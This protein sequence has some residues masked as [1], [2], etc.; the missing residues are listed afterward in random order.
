MNTNTN[1][2]KYK[3]SLTREQRALR[4]FNMLAVASVVA[5]SLTIYGIAYQATTATSTN[6]ITASVSTYLGG[7][8]IE[9]DDNLEMSDEVRGNL[10][11]F[12]ATMASWEAK[13][14]ESLG[15]PRYVDLFMDYDE[16]TN[17]TTAT[18]F[19]YYTDSDGAIQEFN[20]EKVFDFQI[21]ED[22]SAFGGIPEELV[23]P[24]MLLVFP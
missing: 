6:M 24:D 1:K 3:T 15:I 8:G 20:E 4:K 18:Y 12:N 9:M 22:L 13:L 19:G 21:A 11:L 17:K 16:Q 10:E 7:M 5:S 2:K 14:D 23:T